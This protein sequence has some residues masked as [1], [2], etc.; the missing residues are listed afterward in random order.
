[1]NI[2]AK[3]L[4]FK[5]L[6]RKIK[7]SMDKDIVIDNCIGQ[8]YIASGE[9][10]KNI[11]INGVPGNALGCYLN[12]ST[13]RVNGNAQ[14]ATGDTMNDGTIYIHGHCGDAC[15]YAMRGG[16][17]FIRDNAGY[18]T[19][20]HMKQYKDKKPV[21]VIGGKVGSFL[22]EYLAGGIIIVLGLNSKDSIPVGDF[23][24]TGMH[25]GKIYLR[26]DDLPKDLPKQV[27]SRKA[28]KEDMEEVKEY[29]EEF[30]NEFKVDIE[31]VLK[32]NFFCLIPDT[33]NPYRQ[34]YTHN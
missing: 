29:I 15:G 23:C 1:M 2:D 33:K 10:G 28:T 26:S 34:L 22:G 14:D 25:G 13:V 4:H 7:D 8:R 24:G 12:G 6:N 5:E 18:R 16:K 17:I 21:I 11:I 30:C 31:D 27:I 9:K 3:N 20:I 19:G 32:E